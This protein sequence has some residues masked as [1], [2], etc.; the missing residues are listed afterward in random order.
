MEAV[1]TVLVIV[2]I[3]VVAAVVYLWLSYNRLIR[4]R[5]S[6][7]E[8]WSDVL[9]QLTRRADL[10][11]NLVTA[12]QAY[13]AQET[14]LYERLA[15]AR[16]AVTTSTTP[17]EAAAAETSLQQGVRAL[18]AVAGQEPQLLASDTYLNLQAQLSDTEDKVAASR[19]IYNSC[20]RSFNGRLHT[21]PNGLWSHGAGF[22]EREYF[23]VPDV[24]SIAEPP[25]IQF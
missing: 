25:R 24:A 7:D 3:V 14:Q 11:P 6:V 20:V 4:A 15:S 8:T 1:L 23:E 9:V 10:I 12:V 13:A 17:P 16:G 5:G 22:V 18:V 19:R 21:F 2:A